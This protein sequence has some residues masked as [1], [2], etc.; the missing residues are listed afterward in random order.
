ML[1]RNCVGVA[2]SVAD[3]IKVRAHNTYPV[4]NL[5]IKVATC[6]QRSLVRGSNCQPAAH[7]KLLQCFFTRRT[8]CC[9]YAQG[10]DISSP[11]TLLLAAIGTVCGL[12]SSTERAI[13]VKVRMASKE[14][15][16]SGKNGCTELFDAILDFRFW[17][18]AKTQK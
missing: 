2:T 3:K 1:L 8:A 14:A 4:L 16:G 15:E 18:W 17:V 7:S 5:R 11:V 12:P 9:N 6:S 10:E 13:Y